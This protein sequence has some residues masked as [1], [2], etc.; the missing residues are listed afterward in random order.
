MEHLA[1]IYQSKPHMNQL[2]KK[3]LEEM[4]DNEDLVAKKPRILEEEEESA[5]GKLP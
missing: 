5:D 1:D 4:F 3:D 2:I